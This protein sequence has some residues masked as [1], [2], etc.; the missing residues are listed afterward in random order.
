MIVTLT[1]KHPDAM[2]YALENFKDSLPEM[3]EEEKEEKTI[4][5]EN[6]LRKFLEYDEYLYVDIDLLRET[7]TVRK[8]K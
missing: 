5:A 2:D 3:S 6:V 4:L 7:A 1:M 8:I